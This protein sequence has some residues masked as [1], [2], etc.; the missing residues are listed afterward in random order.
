MADA[1]KANKGYAIAGLLLAIAGWIGGLFL[2]DERPTFKPPAE[3]G[4]FALVY[5]LAQ[6]IERVVEITLLWLDAAFTGAGQ[7]LAPTRKAE[8]VRLLAAAP[9]PAPATAEE[10]EQAESDTRALAFGLAA[11][12]AFVACSYFEIG[13]L[14]MIGVKGVEPWFDRF[15]SA[16]VV[17][18]GSKPLHD[19]ISKIQKSKQK[20]EK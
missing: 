17:A 16:V 14:S 2:V 9:A 8:A 3:I 7:R 5:V 12:L 13:L 19:L 1:H 18:G 4:L 11:G 15:V 10:A 6:A 20:D